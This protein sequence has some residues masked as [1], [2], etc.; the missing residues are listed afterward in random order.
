MVWYGM[1]WYGMV[2]YG[3][4]WYGMVFFVQF[5]GTSHGH[6]NEPSVPHVKKNELGTP[7]VKKTDTIYVKKSRNLPPPD[8]IFQLNILHPTR[9][10][11]ELNQHATR[12]LNWHILSD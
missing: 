1:V 8:H 12:A 10:Q 7:H 4:V 11:S 2:W 5:F 9:H 6:Q 3:M